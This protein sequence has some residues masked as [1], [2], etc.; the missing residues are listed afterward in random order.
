MKKLK[1]ALYVV[2]VVTFT[3]FSSI[4]SLANNNGNATTSETF[5]SKLRE[6]E[7]EYPENSYWT[8]DGRS[9]SPSKKY[10]ASWEC[11]GFAKLLVDRTF[12]FDENVDWNE[13]YPRIKDKH[14]DNISLGD[15]VR[16]NGVL[17]GIYQSHSIFVRGIDAEYIYAYE[18]L[19]GSNN[20]IKIATKYKRSEVQNALQDSNSSIRR[21]KPEYY[22]RIFAK[23][24]G[25]GLETQRVKLEWT[26]N[27]PYS[28]TS[29][30]EKENNSGVYFNVKKNTLPG[31]GFYIRAVY[32]DG[33]TSNWFHINDYNQYAINDGVE[34]KT[35][36][37]V[38]LETWYPA[39][40][41][42]NWGN[43]TIDWS[44]DYSS[45]GATLLY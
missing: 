28:S 5:E 14:V 30:R 2:C 29:Y 42:Y 20:I 7:A 38:C 27:A 34:G 17:N 33:S 23:D 11:A 19:G 21:A 24:S 9:G 4:T 35:G 32:D 15:Y 18:C 37:S 31:S 13:C 43:V 26:K 41:G 6:F 44:P 8:T 25:T 12:G 45:M 1:G 10:R 16:L 39:E 22:N 40:W 3:L 36:H